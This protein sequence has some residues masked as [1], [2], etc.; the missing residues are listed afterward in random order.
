MF[1]EIPFVSR[2]CLAPDAPGMM[3]CFIRLSI[4]LFQQEQ[5]ENGFMSAMFT[6]Y[7]IGFCS[8]SKVAPVQYEQELR[9][10]CGAE[11][12]LK[13]PSVNRSSICHTFQGHSNHFL[14]K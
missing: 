7:L 6:L 3:L 8:V 13:R 9:F 10:R 1:Q 14:Q 2:P 5:S 12:V 11:I 4:V